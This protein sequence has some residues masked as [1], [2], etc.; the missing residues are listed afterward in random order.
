MK[1]KVDRNDDRIRGKSGEWRG[2][3]NTYMSPRAT[4]QTEV[5]RVEMQSKTPDP[6]RP[7]NLT[8]GKTFKYIYDNNGRSHMKKKVDRNDDR[9][10][11][12]SG[13][14]RGKWNTYMSPRKKQ[15]KN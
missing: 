11:G 6:N 4:M 5:I 9:I 13:E 10:R 12:K 3:W 8:V 15:S 2:K 14:W 7:K 1:K